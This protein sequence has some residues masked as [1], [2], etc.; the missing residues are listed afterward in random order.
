[1]RKNAP[2]KP[3][4]ARRHKPYAWERGRVPSETPPGERLRKCLACKT[5]R[6]ARHLRLGYCPS[7]WNPENIPHNT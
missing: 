3:K 4:Q 1:M 5:E 7:C 2:H 6:K